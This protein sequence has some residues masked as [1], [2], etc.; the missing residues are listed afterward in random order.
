[1][2]IQEWVHYMDT[3]S[4]HKLVPNANHPYNTYDLLLKPLPSH[5][6]SFNVFY[7]YFN[8]YYY[9]EIIIPTYLLINIIGP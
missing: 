7:F 4:N 2:K 1:M 8:Y 5:S 9:Y 6:K 3:A